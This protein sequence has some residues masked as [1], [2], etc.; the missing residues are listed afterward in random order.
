MQAEYA[1]KMILNAAPRL[2]QLTNTIFVQYKKVLCILGVRKK[3][4]MRAGHRQ[5]KFALH[6]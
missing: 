5:K 6:Q 4:F 3:I 1:V 2:S